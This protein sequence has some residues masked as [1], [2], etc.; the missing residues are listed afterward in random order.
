[1][2]LAMSTNVNHVHK[3]EVKKWIRGKNVECACSANFLF[4]YAKPE[5]AMV[6]AILSA[7][8]VPSVD[9]WLW[10]NVATN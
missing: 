9:A 5:E 10:S 2:D 6:A 7:L 1:M 8:M 3:R 4:E